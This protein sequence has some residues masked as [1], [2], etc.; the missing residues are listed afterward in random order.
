M[1]GAEFL[2][3]DAY[4]NFK[5]LKEQ[6]EREMGKNEVAMFYI[7]AHIGTLKRFAPFVHGGIVEIDK[8]LKMTNEW[9][10]GLSAMGR[11]AAHIFNPHVE[12]REI[13][14]YELFVSLDDTNKVIAFNALKLAYK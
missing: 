11:L 1:N 9:G 7:L 14:P 4:E 8:I 3:S 2:N 5:A 13:T 12:G 10:S 6:F